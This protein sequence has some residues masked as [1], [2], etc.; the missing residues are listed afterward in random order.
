LN[1]F[2]KVC[3]N[4]VLAYK[5]LRGK[6]IIKDEDF[7]VFAEAHKESLKPVPPESGVARHVEADFTK[8]RTTVSGDESSR[9]INGIVQADATLHDNA[10]VARIRP[11]NSGDDRSPN[12]L[13]FAPEKLP[14]P[15]SSDEHNYPV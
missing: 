10:G 15:G 8:S 6:G 9:A 4:L 11:Q 12:V 14:E 5:V 7:Q 3:V 2:H 1:Q 13:S